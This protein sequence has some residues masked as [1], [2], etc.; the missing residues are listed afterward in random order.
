[1]WNRQHLQRQPILLQY[2]HHTYIQINHLQTQLV[3]TLLVKHPAHFN[4]VADTCYSWLL[5]ISIDPT[6]TWHFFP[7]GSHCWSSNDIACCSSSNGNKDNLPQQPFPPT[8]RNRFTPRIVTVSSYEPLPRPR[9]TNISSPPSSD[10]TSTTESASNPP[11]ANPH[12]EN[13]PKALYEPQFRTLT[14]SS[15]RVSSAVQPTNAGVPCE[16]EQPFPL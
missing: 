4:E 9:P 15:E 13:C 5:D 1:M 12:I 7:D 8:F 11:T 16:R 2:S 10:P 6:G 14:R 3:L